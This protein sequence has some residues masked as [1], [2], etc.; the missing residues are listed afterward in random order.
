MQKSS[1]YAQFKIGI[2]IK[3]YNNCDAVNLTLYT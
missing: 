3:Y 2:L 1:S